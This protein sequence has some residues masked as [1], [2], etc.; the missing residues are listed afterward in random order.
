MILQHFIWAATCGSNDALAANQCAQSKT[1]HP[2]EIGVLFFP[3][4]GGGGLPGNV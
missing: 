2:P 3:R 4:G 1:V